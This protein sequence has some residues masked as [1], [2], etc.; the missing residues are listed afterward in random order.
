MLLLTDRSILSRFSKYAPNRLALKALRYRDSSYLATVEALYG[1]HG[2]NRRLR[3]WRWEQQFTANMGTEWVNN[4][5]RGEQWEE[6]QGQ[7]LK[8]RKGQVDEP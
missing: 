4:A 6:F 3:V 8:G 1:Q 5:L 7:W 2:H